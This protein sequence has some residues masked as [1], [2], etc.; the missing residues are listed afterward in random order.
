MKIFKDFSE[1]PGAGK[2]SEIGKG[3]TFNTL[4]AKQAGNTVDDASH[5][6]AAVLNMGK[7]FTVSGY[8]L[9]V[10]SRNE[11]LPSHVHVFK[12]DKNLGKISLYPTVEILN[13]NETKIPEGSQS[14]LKE[15]V[16]L[17]KKALQKEWNRIN[18]KPEPDP[19]RASGQHDG[20]THNE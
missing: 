11:H 8:D 14:M 20:V 2:G 17:N 6:N 1:L 12:D 16:K 10:L 4:L 13:P 5:F 18:G 19:R 9:T 7:M 3:V 15:F